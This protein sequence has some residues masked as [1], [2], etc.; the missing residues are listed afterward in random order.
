M[1]KRIYKLPE[2]ISGEVASPNQI[3]RSYG[4]VGFALKN[5]KTIEESKI[6]VRSLSAYANSSKVNENEWRE[7]NNLVIYNFNSFT[8]DECD[9]PL[10]W[11]R[12]VTLKGEFIFVAQLPQTR[13]NFNF[14]TIIFTEKCGVKE[15]QLRGVPERCENQFFTDL[16]GLIC[17]EDAVFA[18]LS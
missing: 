14:I 16:S 4:C 15:A 12:F 7:V 9:T 2:D 13:E 5:P 1:R 10:A 6:I 17:K 18:R 11:K 3:A 8:F